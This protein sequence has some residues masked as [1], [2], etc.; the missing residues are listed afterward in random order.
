MQAALEVILF[1]EYIHRVGPKGLSMDNMSHPLESEAER[2][3]AARADLARL[4]D[5]LMEA[6]RDGRALADH[7]SRT[8]ID[9]VNAQCEAIEQ[10]AQAI[11]RSLDD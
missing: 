3:A 4:A 8:I 6:A 5:D 11:M 9:I 1:D 10:R 2:V 7:L